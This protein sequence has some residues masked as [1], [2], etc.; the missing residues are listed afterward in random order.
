MIGFFFFFKFLYIR[1]S[2][3]GGFVFFFS[4]ECNIGNINVEF[5]SV[6]YHDNFNILLEHTLK[7]PNTSFIGRV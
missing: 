5:L 2:N 7:P 6:T 3:F 4:S 1:F